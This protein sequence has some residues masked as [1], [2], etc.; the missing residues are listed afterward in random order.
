MELP[1]KK[2]DTFENVKETL[3][4]NALKKLREH[5]IRKAAR[6]RDRKAVI[7]YD[8]DQGEDQA[9]C[10]SVLAFNEFHIGTSGSKYIPIRAIKEIRFR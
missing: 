3:Q 9:I 4:C 10:D 6:L 7:I 1:F 5:K 2:I 8:S